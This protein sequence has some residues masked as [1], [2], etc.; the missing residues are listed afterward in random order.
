MLILSKVY[1]R[2]SPLIKN[3]PTEIRDLQLEQLL[4]STIISA[5]FLRV[6]AVRIA[7]SAKKQFRAR[8]RSK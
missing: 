5:C 6:L 3:Q 1:L 8:A 2:P 7:L 4:R